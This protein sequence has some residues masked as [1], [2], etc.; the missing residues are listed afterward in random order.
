MVGS[1]LY[2]PPADRPTTPTKISI[3]GISVS[4]APIVNVGVLDNGELEIPGASEVG[5][6]RHG[7]SPGEAGSS[8][9]AAHIAFN[10]RDGVFRQLSDVAVGAQVTIE[11]DD[12]Q[13][14]TFEVID[15]AQYAK[16]DLPVDDL[17]SRSGEPTLA[18]IT[19]GGS[20]NPSLSSYEDNVVVIAVPVP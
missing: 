17:F 20:F 4:D 9:L 8:V 2:Q 6:Y 7:P 5:W 15:V 18:L 19:C 1:A 3:D 16:P 10:G 13:L 11:Y 14:R 12:E